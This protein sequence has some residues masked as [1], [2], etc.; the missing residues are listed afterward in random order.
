MPIAPWLA[1]EQKPDLPPWLSV[2]WDYARR[3][4]FGGLGGVGG[5][6]AAGAAGF[7]VLRG[8][9]PV[10]QVRLLERAVQLALER[11]GPLGQQLRFPVLFRPAS[12]KLKAKAETVFALGKGEG[13][14][15]VSVRPDRLRMPEEAARDVYHELAHIPVER[16]PLRALRSQGDEAIR[17]LPTEVLKR[18][19]GLPNDYA[20]KNL[21]EE[22][23]VRLLE[24]RAFP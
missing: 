20:G 21:L 22:L 23:V 16:I 5:G 17:E 12:P 3:D 2:L 9:A 4:P 15:M 8:T 14:S 10:E 6:G 11:L 19:S 1:A 18:I 24:H 7:R 13:P